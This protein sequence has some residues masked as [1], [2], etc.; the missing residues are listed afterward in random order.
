MRYARNAHKMDLTG[1]SWPRPCH[2][3]QLRE[4]TE[5]SYTGGREVV[6]IARYDH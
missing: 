4:R 3:L 6:D 1:R 5:Y 2:A